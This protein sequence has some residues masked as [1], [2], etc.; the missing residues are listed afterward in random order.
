MIWIILWLLGAGWPAYK[1]WEDE[2][3]LG[4]SAGFFTIFSL[5][6]FILSAI[7]AAFSVG[8][9]YKAVDEEIAIYSLRDEQEISGSFILGSGGFGT[10][11]AYYFFR[12]HSGGGVIRDSVRASRTPIIEDSSQEPHLIQRVNRVRSVN[13]L[14]AHP[15][16]VFNQGEWIGT[17]GGIEGRVLGNTLV[18]P[19]G[20]II[21]EFRVE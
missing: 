11:Q 13:W 5:V 2:R 17:T 7:P 19:E 8:V 6:C 12:D 4:L 18:V 9:E 1:A 3:S 20:T 21:K 10:S 15:A 14:W 16:I